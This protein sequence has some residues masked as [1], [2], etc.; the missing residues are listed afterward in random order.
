MLDYQTILFAVLP[1]YLTMLVGAGARRFGVLPAAADAGLMRLSVNLLFPCLIM[2][3]IVGNEAVMDPLRVLTAASLGFGLVGLGMAV[4]YFVAPLIGL[5]VGEGRRT[6]GM[7]VGIQNY[8]FVAIPVIEA[9]FPGKETVG[10]MFTFTLG[11]ELAVWILGV[12]ILK[13]AKEASWRAALNAPVMVI[14][15]ALALN[16][17][18]FANIIPKPVHTLMSNLGACSIPLSVLL[19]GASIYD[20]WGQ[21]PLKWE[22][23]LASP[24]LRL[25][26]IPVAFFACAAWL[27]LGTELRRVLVIQAAMPSAVFGIVLARMYGGH[28]ATAVQVVIATTLA[29]LATTPSVIAFGI[30]W[31]K[32]GR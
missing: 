21:E 18:H 15:A 19:I 26:I 5:R 32:L 22:V 16:F 23:A 30:Q 3:R 20:I 8:G 24:L 28:A 11:V 10:V 14:L 17:L 2:E 4:A 12:G 25:G 9:L 1:V 13:G 31:L 7:S 6:F 29:S 27:P